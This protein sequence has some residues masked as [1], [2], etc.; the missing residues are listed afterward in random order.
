MNEAEKRFEEIGFW[1]ME[2]VKISNK[3]IL[4]MIGLSTLQK[5]IKLI[6]GKNN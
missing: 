3:L 4:E 1:N 2:C 6:V 5:D